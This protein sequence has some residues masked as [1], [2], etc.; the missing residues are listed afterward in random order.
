[1]FV[2]KVKQRIVFFYILKSAKL[3]KPKIERKM[4]SFHIS[5]L[6]KILIILQLGIAMAVDHLTVEEAKT[7]KHNSIK[8]YHKKLKKQDGAIRLVGG[9]NDFEG[10]C[11]MKII[12]FNN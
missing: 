11:Q 8:K 1:M 2:R 9:E 7:V 6:F 5:V 12:H 3:K 10:D 4:I